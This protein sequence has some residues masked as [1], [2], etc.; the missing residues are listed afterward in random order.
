MTT[1]YQQQIQH[2]PH[3]LSEG[4]QNNIS[5]LLKTIIVTPNQQFGPPFGETTIILLGF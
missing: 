2:V 5:C 3:T 1:Y 4:H